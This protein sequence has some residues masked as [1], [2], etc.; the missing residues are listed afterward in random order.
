MD[1]QVQPES[2]G[3]HTRI[4]LPGRIFRPAPSGPSFGTSEDVDLKNFWS[5]LDEQTDRGVAVLAAGYLEWRLRESIKCCFPI[6]DDHAEH[7]FGSDRKG[8]RMGFWE[9]SEVA[10]SLGLIGPIALKDLQRIGT[11]RNKFAHNPSVNSFDNARVTELVDKL[12]T[13]GI[14]VTEIEASVADNSLVGK[15]RFP[16]GRRQ[17]YVHTAH[18]LAFAIYEAG[19]HVLKTCP[20]RTAPDKYW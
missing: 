11:I 4:F 3:S 14:L 16:P 17:K 19:H 8:G 18:E 2:Y 12:E 1:D 10:Y 7:V 20:P 15:V 9:N 6:W 5:E 13:P